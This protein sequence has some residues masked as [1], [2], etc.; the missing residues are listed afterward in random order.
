MFE[1]SRIGQTKENVTR[2]VKVNVGSKVTRDKIIEK[3]SSLKDKNEFWKKIYVKK[4]VHPLYSKETS[5]L[6]Q[7]M[8]TLKEENPNKDVK[9][10][11]GKLMMDGRVVDKN[12]FFR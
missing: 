7:K 2:L 4:D 10:L 3:A 1:Y 11:E 12:L 9:I 6:Y 8:K 5:R